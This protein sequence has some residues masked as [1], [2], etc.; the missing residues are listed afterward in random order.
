MYITPWRSGA[1]VCVAEP[2]YGGTA[3]D[4]LVDSLVDDKLG[5]SAAAGSSRSA[6]ERENCRVFRCGVHTHAGVVVA[7]YRQ[8]LSVGLMYARTGMLRDA[9]WRGA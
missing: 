6:G 7:A 8:E 2:V 5:H 9:A 1:R 3:C 4:T